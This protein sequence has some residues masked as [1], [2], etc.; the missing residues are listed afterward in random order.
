M[1]YKIVEATADSKAGIEFRGGARELW[2]SKAPE[3]ILAGPAD[4]GKTFSGLHKLDTLCWKYNGAQAAIVRK[5]QKS[6]YGSVCVTYQQK[7]ANM[8]AITAFGGDKT[9]DRYIYPNGSVI[10]LGGMDNPDKVLS[11]ERDFI[12]VNQ[13]EELEE[14]DWETLKTRCN[15][16]AGNSPYAQQFGDCNPG[17]SKHWIRE[18]ARRGS[19]ILLGST[20][21]DNPS[22]Y[23][24]DGTLTESGTARLASLETLTGVRRKRL[25]EGI[26]A[27]A[28][29][30]V[31]DTFDARVHVVE[32]PDSEIKFWYLAMDEGYTNPAVILL[33]GEDADKRLHIAKEYYERGKLQR[34]V[35]AFACG[36]W[37]KY[38]CGLAAVDAAAAGLIADLN[39]AGIYAVPRKGRV[40]DGIT[41]MQAMLKV[42]G[43]KRPRLTVDPG[44][45]NVINEFESYVWKDGKDEPVKEND[46]ALDACRYFVVDF[47][48][49]WLMAGKGR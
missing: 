9:P 34:D 40:L 33:I 7:V 49:S 29:G 10:W 21:R 18:R 37:E 44:C 2:Q 4:T 46:H 25:L 30:A 38:D 20:H 15:G 31:Y 12:Y 14:G 17:G 19:L 35:V 47:E 11:S 42:Q 23:N 5:T 27:T 36:W 22:V 3:V 16:R 39:D 41:S 1:T 43:D 8:A 32:R 28:E 24:T 13:A 6:L 26:W 48:G 45:V